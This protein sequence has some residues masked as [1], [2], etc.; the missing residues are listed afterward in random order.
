M[1][2][3]R[4]LLS[5]HN[6]YPLPACLPGLSALWDRGRKILQ[7]SEGQKGFSVFWS[8]RCMRQ[9]SRKQ[10]RMGTNKYWRIPWSCRSF[11]QEVEAAQERFAFREEIV[12]AV[13]FPP[14]VVEESPDFSTAW[15]FVRKADSQNQHST[16]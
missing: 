1:L 13:C 16:C 7:G 9:N 3:S 10:I 11:T 2:T 14:G 5:E 4:P 15:W 12:T 6:S 8:R